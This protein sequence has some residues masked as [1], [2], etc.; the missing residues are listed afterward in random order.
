MSF[1]YSQFSL[2][3]SGICR[4]VVIFLVVFKACQGR[5]VLRLFSRVCTLGGITPG[6]LFESSYFAHRA[7]GSAILLTSSVS[8]GKVTDI[9][10][11][12]P[13][14]ETDIVAQPVDS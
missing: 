11:T 2:C 6:I 14:G 12:T 13:V 4:G 1:R 8:H 10:H 5:S 3:G 9:Q 7:T